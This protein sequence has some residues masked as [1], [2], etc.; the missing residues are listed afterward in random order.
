MPLDRKGKWHSV[1]LHRNVTSYTLHVNC[2]KEYDVAVTSRSEYQESSL[3]D[4][5]IWNFK[6]EGND[7]LYM[8]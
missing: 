7:V 3:S 2:R 6:T 8:K 5:K 4:S 1:T